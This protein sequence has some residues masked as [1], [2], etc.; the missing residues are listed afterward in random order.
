MQ[1]TYL[2]IATTMYSNTKYS[3]FSQEILSISDQTVQVV[4]NQ[5]NLT[6]EPIGAY[7]KSSFF[8]NLV[9]GR[10]ATRTLLQIMVF[11][12]NMHKLNVKKSNYEF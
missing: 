10:E 3:N 7:L 1:K 5:M 8:Q 6:S 2:V 12:G 4:K 11:A 9:T